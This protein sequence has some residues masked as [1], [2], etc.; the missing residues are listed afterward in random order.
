[1]SA[2]AWVF[3]RSG[4]TWTQQAVFT[5]SAIGATPDTFG[6]AVALSAD[7]NVAAI[8]DVRDNNGA[9]ATWIFTRSGSTWTLPGTKLIGTGSSTAAGQGASVALSSDG[10]TLLEGGTSADNQK[11]AAWVFTRTGGLWTQQAKLHGASCNPFSG[12]QGASASLS[13]DGGIAIVG[14]LSEVNVGGVWVFKRSGGSWSESGR[15]RGA[16]SS[17][18]F[19]QRY[20]A[21]SGDGSTV[22]VPESGTP[23][24][25]SV[26]W[27]FGSALPNSSADLSIVS[28]SDAAPPVPPGTKVTYTIVVTNNGPAIATGVVVTDALPSGVTFVSATPSQGTC[29]GTTT[30]ICSI[31]TLA[32]GQSA[33]IAL[34]VLTTASSGSITNTAAVSAANTDPNTTNNATTSSFAVT[35]SAIPVFDPFTLTLLALLLTLAGCV[36]TRKV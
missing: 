9:G 20:G 13:A 35:T 36:M 15:L 4:T 19:G 6:D 10:N 7:G 33:T 32:N 18:T 30:V 12:G 26:V 17:V 3:V 23:G 25:Q 8:G 31:G 1:V 27:I 29:S 2:A 16:P 28:T 21:I 22:A 34:A 24:T 11:G 14:T 5:S